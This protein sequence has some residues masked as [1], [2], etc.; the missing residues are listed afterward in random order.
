VCPDGWFDAYLIWVACSSLAL[1]SSS[2]V[3][4]SWCLPVA[5]SNQ[6]SGLD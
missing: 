6:Y 2:G 3:V 4:H 5:P 1:S